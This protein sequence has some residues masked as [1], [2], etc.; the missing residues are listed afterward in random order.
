M[1][2]QLFNN[3]SLKV[4][5][6]IAWQSLTII[7]AA[8][9]SFLVVELMY[10]WI[11]PSK[12]ESNRMWLQALSLI[13]PMSFFL[14]GLNY[15]F[16]RLMVKYYAGLIKGINKIANGDFDVKLDE[17]KAGPL[18]S[19]YKNFNRM[20]K[21]LKHTQA[22]HL[23]F[24]N[25]YSHEFKTPI[26]AIHGFANLLVEQELDEQERKAYLMV[27]AEETARLADMANSTILLSQLNVQYSIADKKHYVLDEQ[28]RQCIILLS[29]SWQAK[30]IELDVDL[31]NIVFYNN[32]NMMKHVW[33]NLLS[34][35]IKFTPEY[36][37][38]ELRVKKLDTWIK[39]LISDTG[40]GISNEAMQHIFTQYFQEESNETHKGLGLGLAIVKR[41][42]D[43]SGGHIEVRSTK[44]L[45]TTF[46]IWMPNS[47]AD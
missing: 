40:R 38:I 31:D 5:L 25:N 7:L 28:I 8:I 22:V 47:E 27:I 44:S 24:V 19:I 10:N 2:K 26:H 20:V 12:L 17:E 21:Q 4:T 11:F 23:E 3:S 16:S 18:Q 15:L 34:N 37:R 46:T 29:Q 36:G 9:L 14:G 32:E 6:W 43:L 42:V 1:K 45:G 41:I 30:H 39:F 13:I 35:A 33:L